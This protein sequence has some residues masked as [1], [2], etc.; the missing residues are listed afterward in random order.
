[1]VDVLELAAALVLLVAFATIGFRAMKAA[2][3]EPGEEL[4]N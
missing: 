2:D 1:M 4:K 3:G